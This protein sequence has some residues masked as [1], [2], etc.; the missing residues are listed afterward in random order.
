MHRYESAIG[1][2][3]SPLSQTPS[4]LPPH[5]IPLGCQKTL[6]WCALHYTSNSHWLC[7]LHTVM[8]MFQCYSLKS[9]HPLLPLSPKVCSLCLGL[10]CCPGCRLVS[11][12]FLN[13]IYMHQYTISVFLFLTYFTLYNRL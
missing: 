2:H 4:H 1:I 9:S 7:I 5:P 6:V 10:L 13:F 12:I 8:Y 3:V 11:A